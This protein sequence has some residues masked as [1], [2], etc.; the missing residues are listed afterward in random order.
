[1]YGLSK[2]VIVVLGVVLGIQC[3][4]S[5]DALAHEPR[6]VAGGGLNVAV[7][8]RTEPAFA[9]M[10]NAFDF[11]VTD[12]IEVDDP[13]LTVT[14]LYLEEDAPDADIRKSS[15]L[16]GELARDRS[17]PNRFNIWFLPTKAGA[18]GFHIEG[19]V[20]GMMVDEVFI[21]R[22]GSQN[23]DGRSFG[24]IESPQKFPGGKK[25]RDHDDDD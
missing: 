22:G 25:H 4:V 6:A 24:C 18:Y 5:V 13:G 2:R 1:M 10:V 16:E 9:N 7:G 8:W 15:V 19:M 12:D 20:N 11:I 17:N 21:C 14:V 3:L 23:P